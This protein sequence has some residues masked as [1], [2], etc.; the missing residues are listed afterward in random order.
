MN[1]CF[2]LIRKELGEMIVDQNESNYNLLSGDNFIAYT[3]T[4]QELL[5]RNSIPGGAKRV[6]WRYDP[7]SRKLVRTVSM[8]IDGKRE[9]EPP[10]KTEF[11]E[12]LAGFEVYWYDR[13]QWLRMT[14][15]S[16]F[17]PQTRTIAVRF[18]FDSENKQKQEFFESA[19]ILPNE[20]FVKE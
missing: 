13:V 20:T 14:G 6:E 17:V 8:L 4:R 16:E 19:F 11:F 2:E 5:A 1:F 15:I 18:I 9:P 12:D 7:G 10:V 3:T